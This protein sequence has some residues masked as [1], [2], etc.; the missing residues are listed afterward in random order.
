M[1]C[2]M[3]MKILKNRWRFVKCE[4]VSALQTRSVLNFTINTALLKHNL[5][6]KCT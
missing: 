5:M 4:R 3:I 6:L 2:E 1:Q